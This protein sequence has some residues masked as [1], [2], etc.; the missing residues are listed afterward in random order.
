MRSK[1]LRVDLNARALDLL[2]TANASI[3]NKFG[4]DWVGLVRVKVRPPRTFYKDGKIVKYAT[5]F[6]M[7]DDFGDLLRK[8]ESK[9]PNSEK[10]K[11]LEVVLDFD[12]IEKALI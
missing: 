6:K 4:I 12:K 1:W 2:C 9:F 5:Y 7:Y 11:E 3:F 8:C 10:V